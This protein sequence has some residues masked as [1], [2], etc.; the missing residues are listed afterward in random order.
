MTQ[1]FKNDVCP[2][3]GKTFY[4]ES[5]MEWGWKTP[6][7]KNVCSYSCQRK[8]EKNPKSIPK[9]QRKRRAVR[10]IETGKVFESVG[11]CAIYLETSRTAIYNSLNHKGGRFKD[12]HLERVTG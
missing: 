8:S 12:F 10:I 1:W 2:V 5:M 9:P 7:G 4:P 11:E 3:C 6:K